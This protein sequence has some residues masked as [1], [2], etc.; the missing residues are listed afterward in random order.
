MNNIF[1]FLRQF[2]AIYMLVLLPFLS[3][4][5][6]IQPIS[7]PHSDS[8]WLVTHYT[9]QD[10]SIPMRDGTK[11]YTSIYA[12]LNNDVN[13]PILLNRT[14]YSIAPYGDGLFKPFWYTP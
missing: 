6:G 4:S 2:A 9:K 13:H 8:A 12:P 3:R 11:L 5:Q 10:V 14:P 1:T 7:D